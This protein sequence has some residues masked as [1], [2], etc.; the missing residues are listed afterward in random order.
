M[1]AFVLAAGFGTRML[2]VTRH[3]SKICLPLAGAPGIV[4]VLRELRRCGVKDFVVN[5]HH[6]ADHVR[7]CLAA[8]GETPL[9]STETEILGT[10]GALAQAAEFLTGGTFL[11]VNGDCSY[12]GIPLAEALEYHRAKG[13]LAT[14]V[15]LDM[16]ENAK[17]GAVEV[18]RGGRVVRIAGRPAG[19]ASGERSLHFCGIHLIEPEILS[20]VRPVFSDIIRDVY[21]PLIAE[22]AP[23][24]G[25]HTAFGWRDLGSPERYL[26][27]AFVFLRRETNARNSSV[28]G[29]SCVLEPGSEIGPLADLGCGVQ[30]GR[31]SSVVRSVLCDNVKVGDGC[32]IE[33]CVLAPGTQVGDR[34]VYRK[35]LL[36]PGESGVEAR[37]WQP[38]F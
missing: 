7:H 32:L 10:G 38:E 16:P 37:E 11:L 33:D 8:C 23:V 29:G 25:F 3:Y 26:E 6:C 30:V 20:R 35:S 31:G 36:A 27:A 22:G 18:D 19:A 14:I 12:E 5:L 2:P 24:Y 4:R 34:K 13:A 9:Y 17:Y 1:K 21:I 28:I 15:L